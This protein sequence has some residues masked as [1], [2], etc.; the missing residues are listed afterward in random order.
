[1]PRRCWASTLCISA[2][3]PG[4]G[5]SPDRWP[6]HP[7]RTASAHLRVPAGWGM[8][9]ASGSLKSAQVQAATEYVLLRWDTGW[10]DFTRQC[11]QGCHVA[12][13]CSTRRRSGLQ[14]SCVMGLP[15][16]PQKPRVK[17]QMRRGAR[18][19]SPR[20]GAAGTAQDA[21]GPWRRS[22]LAGRGYKRWQHV[23]K[24]VHFT[25]PFPMVRP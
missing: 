13:G 10:P 16:R 7:V 2:I 14:R 8:N 23:L 5:V 19:L 21:M 22:G 24:I 25:L 9:T 1:M 4:P 17:Q 6:R 3:V 12:K 20:L 15:Q 11:P 18:D